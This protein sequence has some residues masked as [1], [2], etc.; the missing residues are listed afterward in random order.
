MSATNAAETAFLA[1]YFTAT[2]FNDIAQN[3]TSSPSTQFYIS[4]HTADP[5]DAGDQTT[6]ET[7]YT[8]YSRQAVARTAGGWT[9]ASGQATN[10]A[11]VGGFGLCTASPGNDIT[12]V[13]IGRDST[14]A[15]TLDFVVTLDTAKTLQVGSNPYFAIGELIVTCD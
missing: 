14:G 3:D 15:G 2:T 7:T 12:H 13:G 9:V 6:S 5:T 10:T 11:Q 8:G 1:L 4:L